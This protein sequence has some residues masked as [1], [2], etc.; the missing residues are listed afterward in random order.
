M[1][2]PKYAKIAVSNN[3]ESSSTANMM[4]FLA[5]TQSKSFVRK[6]MINPGHSRQTTTYSYSTIY[7]STTEVIH[8]QET[9]LSRRSQQCQTSQESP[10]YSMAQRQRAKSKLPPCARR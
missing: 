3:I 7:E 8:E 9:H 10:L 1:N 5:P 6:S 2:M 4:C